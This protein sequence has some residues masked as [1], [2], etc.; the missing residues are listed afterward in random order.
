MRYASVRLTMISRIGTK[1]IRVLRTPVQILV[2]TL[3]L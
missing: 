2:I 3:L 1:P